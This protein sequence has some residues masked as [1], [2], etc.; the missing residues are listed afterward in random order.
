M[1]KLTCLDSAVK[2]DHFNKIQNNSA[3]SFNE[4]F[5]FSEG[6]EASI[7][8]RV[9]NHAG[10]FSAKTAHNSQQSFKFGLFQTPYYFALQIH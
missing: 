4:H 5:P 9:G 10:T 1:T 2:L 3:C 8:S 6:T 7:P